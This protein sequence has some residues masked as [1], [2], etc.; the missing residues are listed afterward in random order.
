M[1]RRLFRKQMPSAQPIIAVT[2]QS[3]TR[4]LLEVTEYAEQ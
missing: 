1:R 2:V 3:N 4:N